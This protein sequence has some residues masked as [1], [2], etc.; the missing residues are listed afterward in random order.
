MT[1]RFLVLALLLASTLPGTGC[2]FLL[3][4]T[5]KEAKGAGAKAADVPGTVQTDFREYKGVQIEAPRSELGDLVVPAFLDSVKPMLVAQLTQPSEDGE[6]PAVFPGGEPVLTVTPQIMWYHERGG[7]GGILGS[8]SFA[9]G[10]FR[11]SANG[12]EVGRVQVVTKS[13]ASR[14]EPPDMAEAMAKGL[15]RYIVRVR[16]GISEEDQ[17]KAEKDREKKNEERKEKEAEAEG[18]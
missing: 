5:Y 16:D 13:G 7:A 8:D 18:R 4:R 6:V 14:T 2:S 12:T 1:K 11:L 3:K 9:I 15:R 17:E 10:L